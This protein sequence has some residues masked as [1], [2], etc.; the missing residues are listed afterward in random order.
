MTYSSDNNA[1][2]GYLKYLESAYNLTRLKQHG[3]CLNPGMSLGA[4]TTGIPLLDEITG[5][6][7]IPAGRITEISGAADS[8]K[9]SLALQLVSAVQSMGGNAVYFDVEG[10]F[11]LKYAKILGVEPAACQICV[12]GVAEEVFNICEHIINGGGIE[13]LIID[14]A[15]ALLTAAE[16]IRDGISSDADL[17][18]YG[19]LR[20]GFRR[21][22][23]ALKNSYTALVIINQQRDAFTGISELAVKSTGEREL[24]SRASLRLELFR[25]SEIFQN[26]KAG[27]VELGVNILKS[28]RRTTGKYVLSLLLY[29]SSGFGVWDTIFKN[30]LRNKVI[31]FKNGYYYKGLI[32]GAGVAE[33]VSFLRNNTA[34]TE[35]AVND[36]LELWQ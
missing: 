9:S 7:G 33:S 13:M 14:S 8:G 36:M 26:G 17:N 32:L 19:I 27:G 12:S 1:Y 22:S 11:D 30:L 31:K 2:E 15:T 3:E 34:V 23:N 35:A 28:R 29:Y 10:K 5:Y 16:F 21:L 6:M 4:Y 24:S 18:Y 20:R 25:R